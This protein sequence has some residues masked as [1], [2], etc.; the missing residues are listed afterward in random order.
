M[1]TVSNNILLLS[2][3]PQ[4]AEKIL[5]GK[6]TVE[7]R[8]SFPNKINN[9]DY[10]LIYVTSPEK[11]V[12]GICVIDSIISNS[13]ENLWNQVKNEIGISKL[14]YESYYQDCRIAHGIVLKDVELFDKP[15]KLSELRR[16]FPNFNPPQTYCYFNKDDF[17][18]SELEYNL[19]IPEYVY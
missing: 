13:P 5:I 14:E 2:I 11:V 8:K 3:K 4:F 10:L 7:L 6:K 12:K 19:N 15:I 16:I 9:G 18:N 1:E 17:Q